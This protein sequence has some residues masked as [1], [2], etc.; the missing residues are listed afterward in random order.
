MFSINFFFF[1][2]LVSVFKSQKNQVRL[3]FHYFIMQRKSLFEK[4][5]FFFFSGGLKFSLSSSFEKSYQNLFS[6]IHQ[7]KPSAVQL[8][9]NSS[10]F[11]THSIIDASVIKNLCCKTIPTLQQCNQTDLQLITYYP[12]LF[13]LTGE[14]K[15]NLPT[16]LVYPV[17]SKL[18][19]KQFCNSKQLTGGFWFNTAWK[20]QRWAASEIHD[21][22]PPHFLF[23]LLMYIWL[24]IPYHKEQN[25]SLQDSE[26]VLHDRSRFI[27]KTKIGFM[28]SCLLFSMAWLLCGGW[29]WG[30][31]QG[32]QNLKTLGRNMDRTMQQT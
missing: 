6:I 11:S 9:F 8:T 23:L 22:G 19:C 18:I 10:Q 30:E 28:S 29:G 24:N 14:V 12:M 5:L 27:K 25:P 7:N 17:C 31:E 2:F 13:Q 1:F 20:R 32:E 4:A 26:I 21:F 15:Q 16:I 3:C